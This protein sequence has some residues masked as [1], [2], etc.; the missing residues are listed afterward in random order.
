MTQTQF[1]NSRIKGFAIQK[2][3]ISRN[4]SFV[5]VGFLN[6]KRIRHVFDFGYFNQSK[7]PIFDQ[8]DELECKIQ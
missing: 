6:K 7:T 5:E 4:G 8:I 2:T 1:I 3:R